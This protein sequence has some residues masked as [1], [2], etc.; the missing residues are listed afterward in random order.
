MSMHTGSGH[1]CAVN[2]KR[3]PAKHT[4]HMPFIAHIS[5]GDFV[6]MILYIFT[7]ITD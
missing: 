6:F 5:H 3:R 7:D 2:M 4:D 1:R